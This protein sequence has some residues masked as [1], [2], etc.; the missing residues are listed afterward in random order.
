M[1]E[2]N[3]T[4]NLDEEVLHLAEFIRQKWTPIANIEDLFREIRDAALH[5]ARGWFDQHEVWELATELED[6]R[7]DK[8]EAELKLSFDAGAYLYDAWCTLL[9]AISRK[10]KDVR[11]AGM[12]LDGDWDFTRRT[13][14]VEVSLSEKYPDLASARPLGWAELEAG[15]SDFDG[16]E[17][18][19]PKPDRELFKG[20]KVQGTLSG[21]FPLRVAL[22]YVMYDEKCQGNRASHVLVGAVFA[23]FLGIA[24]HLNTVKLKCDLV[25]ALPE[26]DSPGMVFERTLQT[27]NP[28]LKVLFDLAPPCRSKAEFEACI[29]SRTEFDA[30]S[31]EEKARIKEIN[32]KSISRM[33]EQLCNES[34][35]E[36]SQQYAIE[37]LHH[38]SLMQ[39]AF[40]TK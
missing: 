17:E 29:A 26:L 12:A 4:I 23:H 34:S 33:L 38:R 9:S 20:A 19:D 40:E 5:S 30:L 24:E 2:L 28:I 14:R 27:D 32:S 39:A 1:K 25:A 16:Q 11:E 21:T 31:E 13:R 37:R 8:L 10:A 7:S 15:Y 36:R 22:P 35:E 6:K 18:Y 3:E